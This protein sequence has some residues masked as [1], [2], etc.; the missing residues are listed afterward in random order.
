MT[1]SLA[2]VT[3][4]YDA[5]APYI[6]SFIEYYTKIGVNEFHIVVPPKNSCGVLKQTL[7]TINN[8]NVILYDQYICETELEHFNLVQNIALPHVKSSHILSIDIDEYL[9]ID[10]VDKLL[11][12]DYV[13]FKWIIAPFPQN[14]KKSYGFMD[15][16]SKYLVRKKL[17]KRLNIHHCELKTNTP[18]YF[19]DVP[20]IHYVYRSFND[21]YLKCAISN[22]QSY[23]KTE[24]SQ[25]HEGANNCQNLPLKFKMAAIYQKITYASSPKV[26]SNYCKIND[27]LEH[28][29]V[30]NCQDK[31][32]IDKLKIALKQYEARVDLTQ[33]IKLMKKNTHYKQYGRMPH[34][35]MAECADKSLQSELSPNKWIK[36][37]QSNWLKFLKRKFTHE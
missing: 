2:I 4:A 31:E 1:N 36:V 5:E 28:T 35:A 7:T 6:E 15:G 18:A 23:Q 34:F 21:L 9:D 16:Q 22:Y 37:P 3:R 12:F 29:L 32:L 27:E 8:K 26:V 13:H 17:C 19:S 33:L 25:L 30:R 24:Y 14:D 11:S 20:L 10:N